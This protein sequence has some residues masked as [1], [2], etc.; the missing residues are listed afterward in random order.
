MS[1]IPDVILGAGAMAVFAFAMLG[2]VF[3]ILKSQQ[4]LITNHMSEGTKALV[5]LKHAIDR[6]IDKL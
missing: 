1:G 3:Y 4:S 6:L 5:D 2:V